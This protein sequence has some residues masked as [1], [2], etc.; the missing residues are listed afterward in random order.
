[1]AREDRVIALGHA[2]VHEDLRAT[3][4]HADCECGEHFWG[5]RQV[6]MLDRWRAHVDEE[7]ENRGIG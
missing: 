3:G 5:Y 4:W 2:L 6:D 7:R 1:M